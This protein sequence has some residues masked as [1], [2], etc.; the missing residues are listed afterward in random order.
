[1]TGGSQAR[2]QS[3]AGLLTINGNISTDATSARNLYLQG[4]GNGVVYGAISNNPGNVNG[5]INLSKQGAGT[6]TLGG[7]NTYSGTTTVSAGSNGNWKLQTAPTATDYLEGDNVLFDDS[8]TGG[9]T[10]GINIAN[11]SPAALTFSNLTKNY[12]ISSSGGFGIVGGASLTKN[13]TGTL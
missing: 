2:V 7:A 3:D 1:T 5:T 6:W 8:A 10:I 12:T 4:T 13:G 11:V 9:T